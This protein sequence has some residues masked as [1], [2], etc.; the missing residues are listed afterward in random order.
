[1]SFKWKDRYNLNISEIDSQHRK[2]FEIGARA[3]DL[4]MVDDSYDHYDEI[5]SI[6]Q[7]LL[8]Y[9]EYHFNFEE[10]L[11]ESYKYDGYGAQK[12]EHGFFISKIRAMIS[13]DIDSD[14]KKAVT[15]VIDFLSEWI[16]SHILF[17]DRKYAAYFEENGIKV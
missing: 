8:D 6:L 7:E 5:V 13:K 14:Q 1:M 11:M 15:E 10:R 4:A 9:T 2:L 16:S 12:Q 3:Y 17:S